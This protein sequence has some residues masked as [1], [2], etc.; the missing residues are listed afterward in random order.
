[1]ADK[2]KLKDF[3]TTISSD[4]HNVAYNFNAMSPECVIPLSSNLFFNLESYPRQAIFIKSQSNL[5]EFRLSLDDLKKSIF[6]TIKYTSMRKQFP[7]LEGTKDERRI[8]T[9][10]AVAG[11]IIDGYS[12]LCAFSFLN[13]RLAMIPQ[14]AVFFTPILQYSHHTILE[15]LIHL[16]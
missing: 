2:L 1:M 4:Y 9:Y 7:T 15:R 5:D 6:L 8:I 11:R 10:Q 16:R 3:E 13:L 14:L 12:I